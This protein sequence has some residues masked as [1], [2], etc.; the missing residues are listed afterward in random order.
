M[1][2]AV[3]GGIFGGL[4]WAFLIELVLDNSVKRPIEIPTKLG[5]PLFL[6]I[7]DVSKKRYRRLAKAA[8]A[9]PKQLKQASSTSGGDNDGDSPQRDASPST[10][11]QGN[12]VLRPFFEALRDRLVM[13]FEVKSLTHNPKLIAVTSAGNGSGVTSIATGLATSLSETGDGKVL[14]VDMNHEQGMAHHFYQGK[15]GGLDQALYTS[16][17]VQVQE[18]LYV[19][20]EGTNGDKLL[21]TLPKRFSQLVPQLRI[22]DY[23]YVIFDMPAITQTS[24]T[25]RLA[26]FMDMVLLVV[27]SEKT[28]RQVVQQASALLAESKATV[29]A[30]L[31]KTRTYVPQRLLQEF[32][33]DA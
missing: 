6:S 10:L 15:A 31:N 23:D 11:S 1:V 2:G 13:Y 17:D 12:P 7:P 20:T 4:A 16:E 30:V 24:M 5:L 9:Q 25:P 28:D 3:L 18:N 32:L 27:E 29:C 19:V 33:S 21:R 26:G 14:L 8:L 22:S